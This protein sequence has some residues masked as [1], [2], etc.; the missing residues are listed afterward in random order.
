MRTSY[1]FRA[2]ISCIVAVSLC[3]ASL[4]LR[5]VE[6]TRAAA[7]VRQEGMFRYNG[8]SREAFPALIAPFL[9]AGRYK[10]FTDVAS[11]AF[12]IPALAADYVPQGMCYSQA[13]GCF[14]LAYYYPGG[15]RPSLL[16]LVDAES[17]QFVKSVY[18]LKPG[19]MPYTGH[20]GGTAAW[21][22]HVWVTSESRAW[23]LAAQDLREARDGGAVRFLDSFRPASRGGIAFVA[24]GM[25]W[26]GDSYFHGK[27]QSLPDDHLDAETGNRAWC[28]GY[29]LSESAPLGVKGIH[30]ATTGVVVPK[31]VLSIPDSAQGGCTATTGE[32]MLSVS[33]TPFAPSW[34]WVYPTLRGILEQPP[35]REATID[36]RQVPLWVIDPAMAIGKQMLA[37]MSE[38]V[39]EYSG[40]IY[41][42]YESAA[43]LYRD[44][45]EMYADY[46]F[47]IPERAVL[48]NKLN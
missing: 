9:R 43:L 12:P 19:G 26:I 24:E 28:V 41:T 40:S 34:L 47:A 48:M 32:F 7:A 29:P 8:F 44:R 31:F 6:D 36:K 46:V 21:G 4:G 3:G 39:C 1:P 13:L 14:A 2:F 11:P 10:P 15:K 22:G 18:L 27:S 33:F 17:R 38:G 23:R 42:W 45:S 30:S 37:P 25:L 16:A 5:G 20:A 35:K